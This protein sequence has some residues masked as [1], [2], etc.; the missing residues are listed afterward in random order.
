MLKDLFL[1]FWYYKDIFIKI[2]V[3]T[4]LCDKKILK[5]LSISKY[6]EDGCNCGFYIFLK[7]HK[8]IKY[9]ITKCRQIHKYTN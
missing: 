5:N 9:K 3:L 4:V 7:N 1:I 6:L 2:I 8:K